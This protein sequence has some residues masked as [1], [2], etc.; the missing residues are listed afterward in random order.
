MITWDDIAARHRAHGLDPHRLACGCA[1]KLDLKRVVYPALHSIRPQL[2]SLGVRLAERED[3]DIFP[4]TEGVSFERHVYPFDPARVTPLP[5]GRDV[6]A[7][8]VTS[9]Y[10]IA[11]PEVLAERW[12]AFYQALLQGGAALR[13]GKGHSI[14]AYSPEDELVHFDA[15]VP[16]GE[17]RAGYWVANNDTIQLLDPTRAVDAPEQAEAALCNALNDLFSLG[18]VEDIAIYPFVAAPSAALAARIQNHMK[19]FGDAHGFAVVP[20]APVSDHT[21]LIGATVLGAS[22]RQLPTFYDR[23]EAGD[24]VLVHRP[25]GDLAPINVWLQMLV[26]QNGH[27][28]EL[29]LSREGLKQIVD[30]RLAVLR[31]PN[32][33]VGCLIQRLSPAEGEPFD[34]YRHLKATGDLSGPGI[35]VFRELAQTAGRDVALHD[36]PLAAPE[37]V[38]HASEHLLMPDGTAGTN[39]AIFLVGSAK[40]IETARAEL[41]ALGHRPRVVGRVG[42]P[43]G[44]LAVPPEARAFI[45]DWPDDYSISPKE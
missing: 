38:R 27:L 45:S 25:F 15:Y 5:A 7:V 10:R 34:P 14:E 24:R 41:E 35:D 44:R 4:R 11:E 18:A 17:A 21:L 8:T 42:G 26:L 20:Q 3:A 23:L 28:D 31:R 16:E 12:L 6:R 22:S 2:E 39:G 43:G 29:G 40:V 19:R 1:V 37:V 13:I 33:D 32:L 36:L 30:E 9:A